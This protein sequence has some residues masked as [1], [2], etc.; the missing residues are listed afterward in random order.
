V[1]AVTD[2]LP[3][4]RQED[5]D[6]FQI[7]GQ[8][9]G[10]TEINPVIPDVTASADFIEALE[11]PL[12][13]GRYFTEHDT[14]DTT[15]VTV[16]SQSMARRFFPGQDPIGKRIRHSGPGSGDPWMQIIGVVGDVKYMGRRE[17]DADAAYYMPLGQSYVWRLYLTVQTGPEV[18]MLGEALRQAVQSV[19][20][21]AT[22]ADVT[23]MQE[24]ITRDIAEPRLDTELLG[25]FAGVALL[26]AAVGIYG[27]IA[28]S[29][30]QRTQE[31]GIRMALG[32]RPMEV[33]RLVTRQG[34]DLALAGI[35]IG[36]AGA[37]A[38]TRLL[39][40][41]LFG[42]SALDAA[43]F[44]LAPLTLLIVVLAA[45]AIPALRATRIS[46]VVALR[47]E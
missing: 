27:L 15:P 47:Y 21:A 36:M 28:Y 42:V 23:S 34:A 32:A 46:P 22:V 2:A 16:I 39:N 14:P 8:A 11:I 13:R 37:L 31:I 25:F 10:P 17:T 40:S 24:A 5:A 45:T 4:D 7:E 41:L 30:A 38:L 20:P 29:V 19:N 44:L 9:L 18:G 26:L 6:T 3:P 1:A 33:L 12:V 35:G 43:T